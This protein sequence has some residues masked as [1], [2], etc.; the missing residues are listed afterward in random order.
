MI[1]WD[2][3]RYQL[4]E[5]ERIR[6]ARRHAVTAFLLLAT[7]ILCVGKL[8]A[9]TAG[10]GTPPINGYITRFVPPAEYRTWYMDAAKCADLPPGDYDSLEWYVV[11]SP[12]GAPGKKTFAEWRTH[13][14]HGELRISDPLRS[15]TEAVVSYHRYIVVNAEE[16][17]DS[18]L[19]MHES[20]H[21]ILWMSGWRPADTTAAAMHPRPPFDRCAPAVHP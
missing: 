18:S 8:H 17:R 19:V 2:T 6:R 21:D 11:P 3:L 7:A 13:A 20:L 1:H 4:A 5:R 15:A 10:S 16:W 14:R 12:W 9:Q